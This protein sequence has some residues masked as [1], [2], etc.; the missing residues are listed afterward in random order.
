MDG[1]NLTKEVIDGIWIGII[2]IWIGDMYRK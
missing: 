1:R 2:G